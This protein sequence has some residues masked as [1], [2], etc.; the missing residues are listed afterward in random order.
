MNSITMIK[1]FTDLHR[2]KADQTIKPSSA[3]KTVTNKRKRI[4]RGK[5]MIEGEAIFHRSAKMDWYAFTTCRS[6]LHDPGKMQ[7]LPLHH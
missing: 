5:L 1:K 7:Q 6:H 4:D 3:T 2:L